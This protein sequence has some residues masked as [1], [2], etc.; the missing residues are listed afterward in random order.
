M[1]T[2]TSPSIADG[3][4]FS[5]EFTCDGVGRPPELGWTNA[6]DGGRSL[7]LLLHD[8]DSTKKPDFTHWLA[9]DIPTSCQTVGSGLA[10]LNDF[11]EL[12]YGGP[13]P[14]VGEHRYVFELFALDVESLG[15]AAGA[16][17]T[18]VEAGMESHL[19]VGACLKARY[20][21]IENRANQ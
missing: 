3:G 19:L 13:C 18:E 8:P 17:R 15:L 21:K 2:L 4:T 10:G 9:Y 12:A 7:V 16:T 11:G 5:S 20:R 14:S 6:P 1:F